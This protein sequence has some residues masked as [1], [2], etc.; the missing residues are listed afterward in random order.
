MVYAGEPPEEWAQRRLVPTVPTSKTSEFAPY[1]DPVRNNPVPGAE[2]HTFLIAVIDAE[3][4][5]LRSTVPSERHTKFNEILW[6]M[7]VGEGRR[8]G[9]DHRDCAW[10]VKVSQALHARGVPRSSRGNAIGYRM[11][12]SMNGSGAGAFGGGFLLRAAA[13]AD[14][15]AAF[16]TGGP[17]SRESSRGSRAACDFGFCAAKA[18][19]G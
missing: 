19:T 13:L 14:A 10:T 15:V 1:G 6:M 16:A 17:S 7:G 11:S 5:A 4:D 3:T 18:E 9:E 8:C 2:K 12:M